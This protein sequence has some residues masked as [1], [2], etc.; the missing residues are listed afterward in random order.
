MTSDAGMIIG[1][2]HLVCQDYARTVEVPRPGG[3]TWAF[4]SDG[5]SGSPDTDVGA[6]LLV[7]TAVDAILQGQNPGEA[8]PCRMIAQRAAAAAKQL[9]LHEHS[10][11][12]TLLGVRLDTSS[13]GFHFVLAGDGVVGIRQRDVL[14]LLE[15]TYPS[16]SPY[17]LSYELNEQ[18]RETFRRNPPGLLRE[19]V[20]NGDG[21]TVKSE[22]P[23]SGFHTCF[24]PAAPGDIAFV[25]TDGTGSVRVRANGETTRT[26][27]SVA[28]TRVIEK[29]VAFKGTQGQFVS[30]RMRGFQKEAKTQDWFN[31]DDIGLAAIAWETDPIADLRL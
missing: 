7:L 15:V 6:R 3:A 26:T 25:A 18:R 20:R 17:Y 24:W 11:D 23:I 16:G 2:S 4:V 14:R 12:A 5:C 27:V 31:H 28:F 22:S 13:G 10:T 29:L 8:E 30:R 1:E 21:W 19:H 9:G